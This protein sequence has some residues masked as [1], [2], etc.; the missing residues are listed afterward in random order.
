MSTSSER[1]FLIAEAGVNHNGSLREAFRLALAAKDA[2][3]DAVKFQCFDSFKLWG[4]ARIKALELSYDDLERLHMHCE[5]IG[6]EFM[7]TPFDVEAVAFLA[8][9]LSRFKVASGCINRWELLEAVNATQK[10]VVLSTGMSGTYEIGLALGRLKH[11]VTLL[12]CTSAYPCRLEDVNLRAIDSLRIAFARPV[13]YSDHTSGITVAMAAVA[14]GACVIEKHLTMD[15]N[16][17]GPDHKASITPREMKALR[18]AMIEIEAALGDGVKAMRA[19]ER[20]IA[21]AW[22]RAQ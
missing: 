17:E 3:A 21:K 22:G 9:L 20:D 16:Q 6:I 13:G 2:G 5:D 10:P 11:G 18:L 12:H 19:C 15:R 4:D 7:C 1:C 8:P 14:K